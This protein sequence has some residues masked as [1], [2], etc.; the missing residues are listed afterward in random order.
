SVLLVSC[1]NVANLLLSRA[2][3]RAREVAVRLAMGA[4]RAR[5]VRQL[6]T[7]SLLLGIAGG[8]LGLWFGWLGLVYLR[9]FKAPS[10][11]PFMLEFH[12][13]ARALIFSMTAAL[14]SVLL[15]GLAPALQG[16]QVDLVPALKA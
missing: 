15:F 14:A 1:F 4:S 3:S 11:L 16:S 6:L 13:N 10:D 12:L 9:G 5:L 8:L 2:R 7:E